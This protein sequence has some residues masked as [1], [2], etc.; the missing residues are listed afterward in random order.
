[1]VQSR[2]DI[3]K[4]RGPIIPPPVG[5]DIDFTWTFKNDQ[6]G[7]GVSS[8][9]NGK[10]VAGI[11][12]QINLSLSQIIDKFGFPDQV[13][14]Q[15]TESTLQAGLYLLYPQIN[16]I[17]V[18]LMGEKDGVIQITPQ[19]YI[20]SIVMGT[21]DWQMQ[22]LQRFEDYKNRISSWHGYGEYT[23]HD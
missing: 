15:S 6:R 11:T 14:P 2:D 21:D 9:A 3:I 19:T 7:G 20:F 1:M 22:S 17:L 8:D 16:M 10:I 23:V 12:L 13:F 4:F 18:T 5:K